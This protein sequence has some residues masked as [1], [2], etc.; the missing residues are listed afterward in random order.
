MRGDNADELAAALGAGIAG[1]DDA[2]AAAPSME[3]AKPPQAMEFRA[4]KAHMRQSVMTRRSSPSR[5]RP[6]FAVG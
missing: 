2:P 1:S 5:S 6:L 4:D 3:T